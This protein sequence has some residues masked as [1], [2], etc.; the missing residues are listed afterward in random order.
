MGV[1]RQRFDIFEGVARRTAGTKGRAAHVNGIGAMVD[2]FDA[3]GEVL[4]RSQ[5]FEAVQYVAMGL[6]V[7]GL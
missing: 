6:W 1:A 7:H 2:G 5:Q 4:G 3:V